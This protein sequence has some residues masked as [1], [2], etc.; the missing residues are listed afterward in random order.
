[1]LGDEA[2][3]C[4]SLCVLMAKIADMDGRSRIVWGGLTLAFCLASIWIPLPYLRFLIAGILAYVL[5]FL[6]NL[7][8][9]N[10]P[11]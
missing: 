6:C 4:A 9:P 7:I 3:L 8:H 2:F 11:G 10:P 1:M 5:M